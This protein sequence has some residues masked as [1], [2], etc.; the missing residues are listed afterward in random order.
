VPRLKMN[1]ALRL[2]SIDEFMARTVTNCLFTTTT[3][4]TT[5]A[6]AAVI[7]HLYFEN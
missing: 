3:T 4:T 7:L 1:R 6:A 5:A 2:F